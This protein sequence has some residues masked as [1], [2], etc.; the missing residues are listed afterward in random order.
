MNIIL[1][2]VLRSLIVNE[3]SKPKVFLK[4]LDVTPI[5]I[6]QKSVSKNKFGGMQ[7]QSIAYVRLSL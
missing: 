3:T 7:S 6:L 4:L 2:K 1:L 5:K